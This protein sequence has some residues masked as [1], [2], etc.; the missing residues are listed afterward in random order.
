MIKSAVEYI[1]RGIENSLTQNSQFL[2]EWKSLLSG[3]DEKITELNANCTSM[4]S[5][6]AVDVTNALNVKLE[7]VLE[8]LKGYIGVPVSANDL[9]WTV[10]SLKN[11]LNTKFVELEDRQSSRDDDNDIK[12]EILLILNQL[13]VKVEELGMRY[14]NDEVK[15]IL[16]SK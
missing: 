14:T 13:G 9:M 10:D 3:I 16:S 6:A 7:A 2:G 5:N 4:L 11:E 8:D 15:E 12:D 1:N